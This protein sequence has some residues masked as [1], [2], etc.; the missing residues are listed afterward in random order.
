MPIGSLQM[1]QLQKFHDSITNNGVK[2]GITSRSDNYMSF[3]VKGSYNSAVKSF[4]IKHSNGNDCLSAVENYRDI[5]G[6]RS[7]GWVK[8]EN[9]SYYKK[10]TDLCSFK[11][12]SEGYKLLTNVFNNIKK[13][14]IS[15]YYDGKEFCNET[16]SPFIK[17]LRDL[18]SQ[19]TTEG[20]STAGSTTIKLPDLNQ[21]EESTT[22]GVAHDVQ[23]DSEYVTIESA[24]LKKQEPELFDFASSKATTQEINNVINEIEESNA[25]DGITPEDISSVSRFDHKSK[26]VLEH[27]IFNSTDVEGPKLPEINRGQY[28]RISAAGIAGGILGGVLAVA[29][30]G[31][32]YFIWHRKNRQGSYDVEKAQKSNGEAESLSENSDQTQLEHSRATPETESLLS[33][34][35][36]ATSVAHLSSRI[37]IEY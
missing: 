10:S 12:G 17:A 20:T 37:S 26:E 4:A 5:I 2:I 36:N 29:F 23:E 15:A 27:P 19:K 31:L 11:Q 13:L 16:F 18:N 1:N 22:E 14:E 9:G 7:Y 8:K 3:Q 6:L 30:V 28:I 25:S 33:E 32:V 35:S 21:R 24:P 34:V